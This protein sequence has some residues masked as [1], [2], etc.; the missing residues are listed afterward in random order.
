MEFVKSPAVELPNN[1]KIKDTFERPEQLWDS[2]NQ[3][4]NFYKNHVLRINPDMW[5]EE[6]IDKTNCAT[7]EREIT[8]RNLS[9]LK[10]ASKFIGK[11]KLKL[12]NT[13]STATK[14][15]SKGFLEV[16]D[17]ANE[18]ELPP[19]SWEVSDGHPLKSIL[20]PGPPSN[21]CL[22]NNWYQRLNWTW[23][24]GH[25]NLN[26]G[27]KVDN[28]K[29]IESDLLFL[30]EIGMFYAA[31]R[32]STVA[33]LHCHPSFNSGVSK[34]YYEITSSSNPDLWSIYKPLFDDDRV[35]VFDSIVFTI[36][37]GSKRK[38]ISREI[39]KRL[40]N[41]EFKSKKAFC[42]IL[43]QIGSKSLF[44]LP[45]CAIVKYMGYSV[46]CEPLVPFVPKPKD[47]LKEVLKLSTIPRNEL[48][49][50]EDIGSTFYDFNVVNSKS[51]KDVNILFD[52][53]L[54]YNQE[55]ANQLNFA[56]EQLN[57]QGWPFPIE[58][59]DL[60]KY[61]GIKYHF[62]LWQHR[63]DGL[64]FIRH[65]GEMLPLY[66]NE[67]KEAQPLKRLRAE[68]VLTYI[69]SPLPSTVS[70]PLFLNSKRGD[71]TNDYVNTDSTKKNFGISRHSVLYNASQTMRL[72]LVKDLL[73]TINDL[74]VGFHDPWEI[75][76]LLHNYGINI[77]YG[78]GKLAQSNVIEPIKNTALK[79]IIARTIKRLWEEEI[80]ISFRDQTLVNEETIQILLIDYLNKI[81]CNTDES[82]IYWNSKII[83]S[84]V[85]R[86]QLNKLKIIINKSNIQLTPLFFSLQYHLGILFNSKVVNS[87]GILRLPL[88]IDDL[89]DFS[90]VNIGSDFLFPQVKYIKYTLS[91]TQKLKK[92]SLKEQIIGNI[93]DQSP[94]L[95]IFGNNSN[96][97]YFSSNELSNYSENQAFAWNETS[98]IRGYYPKIKIIIPRTLKS[99]N[100][101]KTVLCQYIWRLRI[102]TWNRIFLS[103]SKKTREG[104]MVEYDIKNDSNGKDNDEINNTSE[105]YY[106]FS[107]SSIL[108][109]PIYSNIVTTGNISVLKANL[110]G[111]A[112]PCH[113]KCKPFVNEYKEDKYIIDGEKDKNL[114]NVKCEWYYDCYKSLYY[115]LIA[116][117]YAGE[118]L[119]SMLFIL[120]NIGY[121]ALQ[122][123]NLEQC[124]SICHVSILYTPETPKFRVFILSL[125]IQCLIRMNKLEEAIV[126]FNYMS[127]LLNQL[128]GNYR[129]CLILTKLQLCFSL[130]YYINGDYKN[131]LSNS[132][133]VE[134]ILTPLLR[135]VSQDDSVHWMIMIALRFSALS[136]LRMG[137]YSSTIV[138][139]E[140]MLRSTI[141]GTKKQIYL[142]SICRYIIGEA[143]I[144]CG[145]YS[146]ALRILLSCI[147]ELDKY[148]GPSH[149][150]TIK[151]LMMSTGCKIL[152]GCRDLMFPPLNLQNRETE[153]DDEYQYQVVYDLVCLDRQNNLVD[154]EIGMNNNNNNNNN[155]KN[156]SN[157]MPE[158]IN[159]NPYWTKLPITLI[160]DD[161]LIMEKSV[162]DIVTAKYRDEALSMCRS[163][164]NRLMT[165]I[166]GLGSKLNENSDEKQ[167][168]YNRILWVLKYEIVIAIFS[169]PQ[170]DFVKLLI[171]FKSLAVSTSSSPFVKDL[172][173]GRNITYHRDDSRI[174]GKFN[175]N[176]SEC[177]E[178]LG[179]EQELMEKDSIS[180]RMINKRIVDF[181][182]YGY[183]DYCNINTNI[184][185]NIS[186]KNTIES[187]IGSSSNYFGASVVMSPR[188]MAHKSQEK[189]IYWGLITSEP[190]MSIVDICS[191]IYKMILK[192]ELYSGYEW[193][194]LL[195]KKV[196]SGKA[197][198]ME[199]N[200]MLNLIRILLSKFHK[201]Y[202]IALVYPET[203]S[204]LDYT[205]ISENN[206]SDKLQE[207]TKYGLKAYQT[208][209]NNNINLKNNNND[210]GNNNNINSC[211]IRIN[212]GINS[213]NINGAN[214]KNIENKN[215]K[216]NIG[217]NF[218]IK[219]VGNKNNLHIR[220]IESNI[221]YN[222]L[223]QYS[224]EV[225]AELML[226]MGDGIKAVDVNRDIRWKDPY[227][228]YKYFDSEIQ[229]NSQ[230]YIP[231][232]LYEK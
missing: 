144:R 52:S 212:S 201:K 111:Y 11:Q 88:K 68:F 194:S 119:E 57:I 49:N 91:H 126:E 146:D 185:E 42:D 66:I 106:L 113:P 67:D 55:L 224:S 195:V 203:I 3:N 53:L 92:N 22:S 54:T 210:I 218:N 148:L 216:I 187:G 97:S 101:C 169:I 135:E 64:Y 85:K 184:Y 40:Y 59:T 130:L 45:I 228:N 62:K 163:L 133:Q 128:Y 78:L 96:K 215:R 12:R 2:E 225:A 118:D 180:Q 77:G 56:S 173:F 93:H 174:C 41:N 30:K 114:K 138:T 79:E 110:E 75:T 63:T 23:R 189:E 32:A 19:V 219:N 178:Y 193:C 139:G 176:I 60:Y 51:K 182:D 159:M 112:T 179:I 31:A 38:G 27:F 58:T 192:K 122:H 24:D 43:I 46:Y 197:N 132:T 230:Y 95:N 10:S 100:I 190:T 211:N 107:H 171:S 69:H 164:L 9:L 48:S 86:F 220:K 6:F 116:K 87:D 191:D 65:C 4:L 183:I 13:R 82:N 175:S 89:C 71:P 134:K 117:R 129:N 150:L 34:A 39:A 141:K 36:I 108:Y 72:R 37:L 26:M 105:N 44:S 18:L 158:G 94:I 5:F 166:N 222:I 232:N 154:K 84:A 124:L 74:Y 199:I 28:S 33:L 214:C 227:R 181:T 8:C 198:I 188:Q 20:T 160:Y 213:M 223:P 156:I 14:Y 231:R 47:I 147:P 80:H 205:S 167:I 1:E 229:T 204:T 120:L 123:N 25:S 155:I 226:P 98:I 104:D 145:R 177:N 99:I 143:T 208:I 121:L 137:K 157:G 142:E 140:K 209:Y 76:E 125:K 151:L 81:L 170:D 61:Y 149:K 152:L 186:S 103:S 109:N 115:L 221:D 161:I 131:C 7:Y 217:N 172:T 153:I 127:T 35:F 162:Y 73:P 200:I 165:N 83:P 196:L 16:P 15:K 21:T 207:K 168:W 29:F 202:I 50:L 90:E 70:L 206:L 17:G 136:T 102:P